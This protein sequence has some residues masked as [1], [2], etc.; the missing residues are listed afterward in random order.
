[1]QDCTPKIMSIGDAYTLLSQVIEYAHNTNNVNINNII[2]A[3][4]VAYIIK[5][6]YYFYMLASVT[7]LCIIIKYSCQSII[8]CQ[9]K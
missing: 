5:I 8:E 1:M 6:L 3:L 4:Y 9:Q 2:H 7:Q